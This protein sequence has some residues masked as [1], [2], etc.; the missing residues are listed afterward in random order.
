MKEVFKKIRLPCCARSWSASVG[1]G[2][3]GLCISMRRH[4]RSALLTCRWRMKR[5]EVREMSQDRGKQLVAEARKIAQRVDSWITLSNALTDP[6]GGLIA[7][8]FPALDQRQTFL[9]SA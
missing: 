7:S 6:N 3:N 2:G 1:S 8:Y 9:R 4:R 5:P